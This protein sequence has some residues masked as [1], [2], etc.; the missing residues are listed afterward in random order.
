[1][2]GKLGWVSSGL[3]LFLAQLGICLSGRF[4]FLF[5]VVVGFLFYCLSQS[6]VCFLFLFCYY[7]SSGKYLVHKIID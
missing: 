1:M 6:V 5:L 7:L 3:V 2:V 4:C